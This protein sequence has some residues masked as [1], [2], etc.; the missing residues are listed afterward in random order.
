MPRRP[1]SARPGPD[2]PGPEQKMNE[3]KKRVETH[4]AAVMRGFSNLFR[5]LE[6][7]ERD[8]HRAGEIAA[9]RHLIGI[10]MGPCVNAIVGTTACSDLKEPH[11]LAGQ[12]GFVG[13]L[14]LY[15][16]F[17]TTGQTVAGWIGFRVEEDGYMAFVDPTGEEE[18]YEDQG[19]RVEPLEAED[20]FDAL[21]LGADW[22]RRDFTPHCDPSMS[23]DDRERVAKVLETAGQ[24]GDQPKGCAFC[25][26]LGKETWHS[27][28]VIP[29][30]PVANTKPLSWEPVALAAIVRE[31]GLRIDPVLLR[32]RFGVRPNGKGPA[33]V[34]SSHA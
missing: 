15:D 9:M 6:A 1:G 23:Q 11:P 32:E 24:A 28:R 10:D 4:T 22:F 18:P 13:G 26:T 25:A 34:P 14:T 19:P 12:A 8:P 30:D 20:D 5:M 7:V 29:A 27:E 3:A 2:E 33:I 17:V 16:H 31:R 21:R